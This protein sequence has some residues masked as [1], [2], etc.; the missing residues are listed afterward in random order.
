DLIHTPDGLAQMQKIEEYRSNSH[1]NTLRKTISFHQSTPKLF[2]LYQEQMGTYLN[3]ESLQTKEIRRK[4]QAVQLLTDRLQTYEQIWCHPFKEKIIDLK[5]N[6]TELLHHL[7]NDLS[8]YFG[9][10]EA[11]TLD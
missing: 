2:V 10:E 3:E 6:Y 11:N 8:L 5:K 4:R 1:S 9:M 7:L